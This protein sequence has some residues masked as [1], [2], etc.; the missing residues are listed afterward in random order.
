[1]FQL[2]MT[3]C[4]ETWIL[5][6]ALAN[7][8][9]SRALSPYLTILSQKSFPALQF[10]FSMSISDPGTLGLCYNALE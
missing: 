2:K 9:L 1:M 10:K 8:F 5:A 4:Q 7:H 6:P 3:W